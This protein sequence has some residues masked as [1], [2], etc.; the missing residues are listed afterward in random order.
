VLNEVADETMVA[1]AAPLKR[2]TAF[3]AKLAP[4]T[5]RVPAPAPAWLLVGEIVAI[6]GTGFATVRV[7]V[8]EL[9]PPGGGFTTTTCRDPAEFANEADTELTSRAVEL[10]NEV[11]W[12]V[13]LII[14]FDNETKFVPV[15]SSVNAPPLA[16]TVVGESDEICGTGLVVGLIVKMRAVEVPPP[17]LGVVIEMLT[18][19]GF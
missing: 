17:G 11:G 8:F 16:R 2:S 5:V 19:P 9:P 6:V 15:R 7:K 3:V 14:T 12:T 1:R 13:P 18:I 10:S 4:V